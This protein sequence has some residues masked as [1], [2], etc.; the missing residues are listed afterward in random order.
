[1]D[2]DTKLELQLEILTLTNNIE[3]FSKL[4]WSTSHLKC[5]LDSCHSQLGKIIQ[6]SNDTFPFPNEN[7]RRYQYSA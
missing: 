2:F 5:R 3:M 6:A 4:G 7:E 1:M